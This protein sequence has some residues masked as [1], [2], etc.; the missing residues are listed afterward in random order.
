MIKNPDGTSIEPDPLLASRLAFGTYRVGGARA[1]L[2]V[3]RALERGI[4]QIDTARLYKNEDE[5]YGA[6]RAFEAENPGASPVFVTSKVHKNLLFDDTV[7]AV[8]D[9]VKR[10]GRPLDRMLLHRPLPNVMWRALD[11][12][13]D[14]GLVSQ[15]GVSNYPAPRLAALLEICAPQSPRESAGDGA[16]P[17]RRP[18]VHQVE[19]HPFVGAVHP[20]LSYCKAEGIAVQ[21]HTLLARGKFLEHPA[22]VRQA[23]KYGVSPAV[24]MLRW[25]DQ[26]GVELLVHTSQEAHLDEI[27]EKV[28]T[29]AALEERDMAE[30]SGYHCMTSYRFFMDPSPRLPDRELDAITDT[31]R[32]VETIASRLAQDLAAMAAG[33]P[34]SRTALSLNTQ[35]TWEILTDPVANQ[36]ALRLFPPAEGKPNES[37]YQRYRDLV[38]SLRG[39]ANSEQQAAP[40]KLSCALPANHAALQEAPVAVSPS[41]LVKGRPVSSVVAHP[42]AMPVEVAPASELLPFFRFLADPGAFAPDELSMSL[43]FSRGTY[44]PDQRMDLCKQVVGPEHIGR[45]CEAVETQNEGH[46][47]PR[48]RVRHFLLGNNIACDGASTAGA[49]A[50]ARLM[51][52][53]AIDIE[54]WYLAGN[55]IGPADMDILAS[56]LESNRQAQAL[57]LKRNPLGVESGAH[58]GRMLGQNDTLELLDLHNT[59]L[60]DE[61][62]EALCQ[63]LA[64][65][66]KRLSLQ[67]LYLSANALTERSLAALAPVLTS[68][69]PEP[70]SL[71]SLYLSINRLGNEALPVLVELIDTGALARLERLDLGSV[72]LQAPCLGPLVDALL[73]HCP[74][75]RSLNLGTYLSTRD[76]GETANELGGDVPAMKRLLQEHGTLELLDI[77]TCGLSTGGGRALV[78]VLGPRQS[79]HGV[80]GHALQHSHLERRLLK[81]P[82]CVLHIDSIYRGRA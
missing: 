74:R 58:L 82:E 36:I 26:L 45:L 16:K 65:T 18:A 40:K 7:R 72:G 43:T 32:Y 48:H 59:G 25:A 12:C 63:G 46:V 14:R 57:W 42:A 52:N 30:I 79:L 38:R 53:P 80:G 41:L 75:L 17:C 49:Q 55:C 62:V 47:E 64:A 35:S 77:S 15:I 9:S 44:F 8:E 20:L 78:E 13:V 34:V 22:L 5:V 81:H 67:H 29:R 27:I 10:L 61:G 21:G 28:V 4:R 76:L 1:T 56:A 6:I 11:A 68:A 66:G 51:A 54:T 60:F 73:Q 37:S 39:R 71:V 23:A 31:D 69:L 24:I 50:M 70:C 33:A 19:F 3:R 2:E